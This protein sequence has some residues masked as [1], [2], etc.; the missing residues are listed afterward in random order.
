MKGERI[1]IKKGK[2]RK[3]KRN[4]ST[5]EKI[6]GKRKEKKTKLISC[7]MSWRKEVKLISW[8][9]A[10]WNKR[11]YQKDSNVKRTL[12]LNER[13]IKMNHHRR[14]VGTI[15]NSKVPRGRGGRQ[16]VVRALEF[17]L[18]FEIC[19]STKLRNY[20]VG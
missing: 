5:N 10:Y 11:T 3:K 20:E 9:H 17:H 13:T 2:K 7:L 1:L 8:I 18:N 16:T 15:W 14:K 6:D 19:V 12:T 4:S